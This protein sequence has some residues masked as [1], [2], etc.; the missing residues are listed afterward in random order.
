MTRNCK[1]QEQVASALAVE[2]G[3]SELVPP[4]LHDCSGAVVMIDNQALREKLQTELGMLGL[5]DSDAD[6]LVREL[7]FLSYTLIKAAEQ[8]RLN[9]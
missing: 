7:N 6:Q 1:N 4:P 5:A 3:T 2:C 9:G 8:R